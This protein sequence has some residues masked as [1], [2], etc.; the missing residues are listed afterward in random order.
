MGLARLPHPSAQNGD[1]F[2]GVVAEVAQT[3]DA[4]LVQQLRELEGRSREVEAETAAVLSELDRA[5]PVAEGI[6]RRHLAG[7][8]SID[9]GQRSFTS[10]RASYTAAWM[11]RL[12]TASPMRNS[13]K[14]PFGLRTRV[15]GL[16]SIKAP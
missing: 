3:D 6:A 8:R 15:C 2:A 13:W 7:R 11:L 12:L 16:P 4:A 10:L 14:A 1:V 9:P 5:S